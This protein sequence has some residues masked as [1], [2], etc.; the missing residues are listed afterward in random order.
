MFLDLFSLHAA[1]GGAPDWCKKCCWTH[2]ALGCSSAGVRNVSQ[3]ISPSVVPDGCQKRCWTYF[4]SRRPS[5]RKKCCWTYF[6]LGS[7][8]TAVNNVVRPN[9]RHTGLRRRRP[10]SFGPHM[11]RTEGPE[12]C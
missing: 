9:Q 6:G 5:T 11:W 3:P 1:L 4:P 7:A 10:S 8:G 12:E 2:F